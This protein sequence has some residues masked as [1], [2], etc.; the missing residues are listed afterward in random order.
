MDDRKRPAPNDD[1]EDP[2]G[3]DVGQG[4]PEENQPGTSP[5]GSPPDPGADPPEHA[6]DDND[7]DA[8][9][10]TGNPDNAGAD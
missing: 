4:Y 5:V 6:P 2:R 7:G 10:A 9:Q 1:T 8:G 3:T